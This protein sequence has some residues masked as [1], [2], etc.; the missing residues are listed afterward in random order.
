MDTVVI[1]PLMMSIFWMAFAAPV[2]N[3]I[4]LWGCAAMYIFENQNSNIS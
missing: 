3:N 2:N 1:S 4:V